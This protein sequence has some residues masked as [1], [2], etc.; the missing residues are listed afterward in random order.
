M[1]RSK[2]ALVTLALLL[3]T[4][5]SYAQGCRPS[6]WVQNNQIVNSHLPEV[7]ITLQ[8]IAKKV[9]QNMKEEQV[10]ASDIADPSGSVRLV[11]KFRSGM[12]RMIGPVVDGRFYLAANWIENNMLDWPTCFPDLD[13]VIQEFSP[14]MMAAVSAAQAEQKIAQEAAAITATKQKI[15]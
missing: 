6:P 8:V 13:A 2:I 15:A 1:T 7:V 10:T 14:R 5:A 9:A 4:A 11:A 12:L 3:S